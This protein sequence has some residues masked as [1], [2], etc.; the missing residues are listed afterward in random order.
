MK[1]AR[2]IF[3]LSIYLNAAIWA[4]IP[5]GPYLGQ[6]F[7][8]FVPEPFA[9]EILPAMTPSI[10]FTSDGL[11]CF[12]TYW[13]PGFASILF[14]TKD[15]GS[16][17]QDPDTASFSVPY[18]DSPYLTP[19]GNQIFFIAYRLIPGS[20]YINRHLWYTDRF[21]SGWWDPAVMDSPLMEHFIVSVSASA[22][23]NLY[24]GMADNNEPGI[25]ISRY[26][27][28]YYQEPEKLSDSINYLPRPLR[29]YVAAD[30]SY[31]VFDA[32]ES[33]DPLSQRDIY[34]SYRNPDQ[35]W[36]KA[37]AFNGAVNTDAD[38]VVSFISRDNRFLF[39]ARNGV[40]HWV[41]AMSVLT[42]V[43]KHAEKGDV[44]LL[45]QNFPNPFNGV[46]SIEFWLPRQAIVTLQI[47]NN[48][49]EEVG[50]L[51]HVEKP[52]GKHVWSFDAT[53]LPGGVY[54]CLL[55]VYGTT[56]SRKMVLKK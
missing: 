44:P 11:E 20:P 16:S 31:I 14:T 39:F 41:D 29:P 56:I 51:H 30:E 7:P 28:G 27:N 23:G 50:E 18:D 54:F 15:I 40:L 26:I 34:I 8:G 52:A 9:A 46:T 45:K 55:H 38:E 32:S 48:L 33:Q 36:T 35:T 13:E 22:N 10:T 47:L 43:E 53:N 21:G 19:D 25:F 12:Y 49:N 17:W 2:F 6:P 24:L 42:S 5:G 37:V 1:T 4:Q 3:F